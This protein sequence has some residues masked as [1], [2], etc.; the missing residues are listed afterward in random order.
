MKIEII[1]TPNYYLKETEFVTLDAYNSVLDSINKMDHVVELTVCKSIEDLESVVQR[2]PD[3]VILAV[4]Y[5]AIKNEEDI[6]LSEYFARNNINHSGSL[7]ETLKFDS[8]KILAKTFLRSK[9][10]NTAKY[11]TAVPG[12]YKSTYALPIGYPLFLKPLDAANGKGID[13]LSI[14]NSFAEFQSK[15]LSLYEI[16][17][18]PVLVEEYIDGQEFAIA[19]IQTKDAN[20]L[21]SALEVIPPESTK[22]LRILGEKV[23]KDDTEVL[24]KTEDNFLMDR[25]KTLAIDAYIDLEIRDYGLINV[26]T[27]KYGHCFF[28]GINLTPDIGNTSS[29]F[30]IACEMAH[31][32]SYDQVI[33][34][35]VEEGLHRFP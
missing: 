19:I 17:D 27:N 26:K 24:R 21:V 18:T 16:F 7:R 20:L 6:W 3:L 5:I 31:D 10:I 23:K 2:K 33:S 12:E 1:T 8:D 25:I 9:G 28:I 15:V 4:K 22:A 13:N 35:I 30:P 29:Y 32:L 14:V 11:F 34:L